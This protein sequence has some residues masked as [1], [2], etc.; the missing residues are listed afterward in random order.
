MLT[1]FYG[2]NEFN[3]YLNMKQVNIYQFCA[4]HLIGCTLKN[5]Q[6]GLAASIKWKI[7]LRERRKLGG[8]GGRDEGVKK[9]IKK[10]RR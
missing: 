10:G 7:Y 5:Q 8:Q 2:G 1:F 3:I 4:T 6:W 9:G